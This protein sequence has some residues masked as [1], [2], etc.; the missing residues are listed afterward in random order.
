MCNY[1]SVKYT[2][3][4]IKEP[5]QM[6][7]HKEEE[8]EKEK[9]KRDHDYITY[10]KQIFIKYTTIE[11]S[12]L[13]TDWEWSDKF[14]QNRQKETFMWLQWHL[15]ALFIGKFFSQTIQKSFRTNIGN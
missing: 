6:L 12:T 11:F 10:S 15:S 14:T 13:S 1:G 4:P 9:I 3:S 7:N 2:N 5:Q 8:E